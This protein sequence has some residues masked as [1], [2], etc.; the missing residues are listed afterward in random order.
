MACAFF[1]KVGGV[2]R[3]ICDP[4]LVRHFKKELETH[5]ATQAMKYSIPPR[6]F[7]FTD[8]E[9]ETTLNHL[10]CMLLDQKKSIEELL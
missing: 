2:S 3:I 6:S 4:K 7:S 8:A 1:K 9:I 5:K 10:K